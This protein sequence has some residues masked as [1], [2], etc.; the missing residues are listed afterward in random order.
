MKF[1]PSV[2]SSVISVNN[3]LLMA[4]VHLLMQVNLSQPFL[5]DLYFNTIVTL[6]QEFHLN[7]HF[8][9]QIVYF[10]L[11]PTLCSYGQ[12]LLCFRCE[13]FQSCPNPE[14]R[15]HVGGTDFLY[16]IF[17]EGG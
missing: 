4:V 3:Y 7:C 11:Y 1:L 14:M 2:L 9:C 5:V 8:F 12:I 17:W 15:R 10:I 13:G 6:F 16:F